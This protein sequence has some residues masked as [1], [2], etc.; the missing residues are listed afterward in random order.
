MEGT[1]L[2]KWLWA[3]RFFK[4]RS[5]AQTAIEHGRVLVGG[6]RVKVA[7]EMKIG[8]EVLIRVGDV[9]RTV[10]VAALSEQR[11]PASV[12]QGL[13]AETESS[14]RERVARAAARVMGVEPSRTIVG[15]PTKRDRRDLEKWR[16]Q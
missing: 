12:A 4:T 10:V 16:E 15:R 13:Y 6:D 7:R 8:D 3:A 14:I 11:G 2:D 5:L 1:R 9:V